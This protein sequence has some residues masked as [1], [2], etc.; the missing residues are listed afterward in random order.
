ML[1]NDS[2]TLRVLHLTD[3][4]LFNES[5]EQLYGVEPEQALIQLIDHIQDDGRAYNIALATGDLVHDGLPAGYRKLKSCLTRLG[6]PVLCLPGNHDDPRCM[7]RELSDGDVRLARHYRGKGWQIVLLDSTIIG[8][9]GGH[10]DDQELAWLEQ[11]LTSSPGDNTLIALHH[12]PLPSGC[13]WMDDTMLLD[14]PQTLF[15]LIDR[16]PQ[17]RG[18]LWGHIHQAFFAI[19][20]EVVLL[21]TPSTAVQFRP[22]SDAFTLD[23]LPA[24]YRWLALHPGGRVETE[25]CRI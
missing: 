14:N 1:M 4:H 2:E 8:Q 7:A 11:C 16:Y 23:D 5:G 9:K 15:Q 25:I 12:P 6:I 21:S 17:V 13:K 20:N 10:L 22:L 18:V 3:C 24:G 19:R